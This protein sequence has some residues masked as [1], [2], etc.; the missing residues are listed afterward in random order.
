[1]RKAVTAFLAEH[2]AAARPLDRARNE[3]AWQLALTGEDRWKEEAVRYAIARRAL[4][5]DPVG[6]R[7]LKQWHARPDD[8]GDPLLA[9][10]VRK[11]YLEF[12]ASQMDRETLE[13]LARLQ[14]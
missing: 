5:A 13:A 1:M 8:V 6:F 14:A 3:A 9:R 12:R 2:E 7:R 11:L 4:S 10:Q